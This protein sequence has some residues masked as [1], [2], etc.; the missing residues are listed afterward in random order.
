M[1]FSL[2]DFYKSK[3]KGVEKSAAGIKEAANTILSNKDQ[4]MAN[5]GV[6]QGWARSA[7]ENLNSNNVDK[8]Y[9]WITGSKQAHKASR[10]FN[11]YEKSKSKLESKLANEQSNLANTLDFSNPLLTMKEKTSATAAAAQRQS[12]IDSL[13]SQY[14]FFGDAEKLGTGI[15]KL[16]SGY[17]PT[18]DLSR[19][20]RM[21]QAA[22]RQATIERA[23]GIATNVA[24]GSQTT[25]ANT[26]APVA[27]TT[28]TATP[29]TVDNT[30]DA[31][32]F[33]EAPTTSEVGSTPNLQSGTQSPV[34]VGDDGTSLY[35]IPSGTNQ[36]TKISSPEQLQQLV[37][38]GQVLAG[39]QSTYKPLSTASSY[40]SGQ[41]TAAVPAAGA[42]AY[43]TLTGQ[44]QSSLKPFMDAVTSM[45]NSILNF[46]QSDYAATEAA[47]EKAY[48]MDDIMDELSTVDKQLAD[49]LNIEDRVPQTTLDAAAGTEVTQSVLD[50]QRSNILSD[51]ARTSA[52]LTRL[53]AVLSDDYDRRSA[54]VD[55]AVSIQKEADSFKLQKLG[56]ALD[57]AVS[58]FT[59]AKDQA[60]SL[61]NAAVK[62][63]EAK[64]DASEKTAAEKK[65]ELKEYNKQLEDYYDAH[66][67][68]LNPQTGE[69]EV[70]PVKRGSGSG[71]KTYLPEQQVAYVSRTLNGS[72]G[73]DGY[74]NTQ[75]YSDLYS[76]IAAMSGSKAAKEFLERFPV[77]AN[78]NP[79]DPS[80]VV[81]F[82]TKP[83]ASAF[84]ADD[85]IEAMILNASKELQ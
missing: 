39:D 76:Q 10:A 18:A 82:G 16:K 3:F 46:D 70:K 30:I 27:P 57:Y 66:G 80:A 34:F 12:K 60:E 55:K 11:R 72:K 40:L 54:L 78:L 44:M 64:L 50:R 23:A 65:A 59:M 58:N 37:G 63:Y 35:Y 32:A 41:T 25:A 14:S 49:L 81:F 71:A 75:V 29:T 77:S 15:S 1:A 43:E 9:D 74:A 42:G 68:I 48:G 36:P 73:P 5:F 61:F 22:E 21:N 56:Y 62:D 20:Q 79:Q 6:L 26:A 28:I 33:A 17:V 31:R 85:S 53:K 8:A 13:K 4:G 83:G 51:L 84:E 38:S 19:S 2:S 52:P 67:Y 24:G 45:Q 7:L 69:F 47:A